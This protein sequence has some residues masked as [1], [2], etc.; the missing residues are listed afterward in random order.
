M[1]TDLPL[2]PQLSHQAWL[3]G[4]ATDLFDLFQPRIVNPRG[5]FFDLDATG[6]P[7]GDLR[8]I[9]NTSRMVHCFAIGHLLGR[10]GS[11]DIVDHGVR[12]LW[13]RHRDVDHGGYIWSFDDEGPRDDTKQA[14]GHAFV[15]LAAAAAKVIGHPLADG[16]LADITAVID[17]RFWD[18]GPGAVREE[19]ARNWSSIGDYRGQNSNMHLTESLMAAFEATGDTE[20]LRKATRIAE[21]IIARHAATLDYAVAEHFDAEWN[22]DRGY[23]GSD[24]FRPAGTTPG[25]WLEWAR[26]LMQLWVLSGSSVDWLP[27]AAKALFRSAVRRGWDHDQGGFFYT[28]DFDHHPALTAKLWWPVA[29][30]IGAAAFIAGHDDD[31][32]FAEWYQRIW[33][34]ADG[35]LIDHDHRGWFPELG[36]DLQP[37]DLFFTGKPD[38]YH[39][40]QACLIPQFPAMG[41]LT[42]VAGAAG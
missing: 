16:L 41:S 20:Y 8:Q 4:Q 6:E 27:D 28:L 2:L 19:F 12:T 10:P 18:E 31:P 38:L 32:F 25:H 37:V 17:E 35:H 24:M 26:L 33:A 39:A 9:H 15:L 3:A 5:G 1:T 11:A 29:E 22:L 14:Y 7:F 34:F 40:L 23:R 36:D 21:L 13:E 42:R 30:G